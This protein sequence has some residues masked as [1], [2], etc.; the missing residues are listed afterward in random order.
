MGSINF[1][2]QDFVKDDTRYKVAIDQGVGKGVDLIVE[3]QDENGEYEVIQAEIKRSAD[4]KVFVVWS[5]PFDGRVVSD[6]Y[7]KL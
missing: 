5:E 7:K 1:S 4:E 2:K 3:R 6:E